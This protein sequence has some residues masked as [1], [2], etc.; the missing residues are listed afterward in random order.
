MNP[1]MGDTPLYR[2]VRDELLVDDV[3]AAAQPAV[4]VPGFARDDG[5]VYV[6]VDPAELER[7]R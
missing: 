1:G 7:R 4:Q 6:R 2:Q 3:P 5:S